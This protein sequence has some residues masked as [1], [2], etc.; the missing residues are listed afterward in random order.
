VDGDD[1]A[2]FSA[3][4]PPPGSV[5]VSG[6]QGTDVDFDG[7]EYFNN[8]PGTLPN[9]AADRKLHAQAIQFSSPTTR[10]QQFQ[11]AAFE[12]DL[13]RIELATSPACN[14]TTGA[15]CVNPP[16]GAGFYPF[17]T[18][19]GREACSWQEGG[20]FIP[21]TTNTFGGSSTTAYGQLL[22]LTYPGPGF[23]PFQ[24]INDFRRVLDSNPCRAG[25]SME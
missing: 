7:P 23:T 14:R 12:A 6:C 4:Q 2:C 10:G 16:P 8:W 21:G 11:R 24:R 25:E 20:A 1:V 15:N 13:P 17:F 9:A 18:T 22:Q 3:A 5:R 19:R